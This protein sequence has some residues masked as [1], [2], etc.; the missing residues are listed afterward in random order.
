VFVQVRLFIRSAGD[1]GRRVHQP[2][3]TKLDLEIVAGIRQRLA[4]FYGRNGTLLVDRGAA[5]DAAHGAAVL[6]YVFKDALARLGTSWGTE[7]LHARF[8][9]LLA[10]V[11]TWPD[12]P[13]DGRWPA[14]YGFANS[15]TLTRAF[16]TRFGLSIRDVRRIAVVAQ[17]V[18]WA[19]AEPSSHR[20]GREAEAWR[21]IKA[22]RVHV[23]QRQPGSRATA[24]LESLGTQRR[25][26]ASVPRY[27]KL[28]A[29]EQRLISQLTSA[30]K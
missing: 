27:P 8:D 5:L 17:W 16:A 26:G 9:A 24:A 12:E 10:D 20:A 28:T 19:S 23:E 25:S 22:L 3:P 21:R 14:R 4:T 15:A 2:G 30:V 11:L 13:R 18:A 6:P 29:T 7:A 1:Y